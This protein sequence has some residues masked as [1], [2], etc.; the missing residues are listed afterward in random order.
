MSTRGDDS[1]GRFFEVLGD[2]GGVVAGID[3]VS[4]EQGTAEENVLVTYK[5]GTVKVKIDTATKEVL[6]ADYTMIANVAVNHATIAV[7][8]DKSASLIITYTN[9]YPASDKY[10]MDSRQIKRA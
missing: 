7:I 3:M 6:E 4:F 9:H 1:Q 2:I 5:G 8:K 10:L